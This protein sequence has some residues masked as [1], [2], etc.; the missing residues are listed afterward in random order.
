MRPK[1]VPPHLSDHI[2]PFQWDVREVWKLPGEVMLRPRADYDYLLDL[3]LW[4]SV[5]EQGMLFDI[6]PREVIL[7]AEQSPF[8]TERVRM[9][10]MRY[11]ID[12][13]ETDGRLW[14]LDGVHRLARHY[15]MGTVFIRV[16]CHPGSVIPRIVTGD[17]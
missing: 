11:P 15:Q 9:A 3:P 5:P 1:I 6:S 13:V 17:R 8:Q 12:F 2:L 7:D 16:R 10:D 4:S 14:I